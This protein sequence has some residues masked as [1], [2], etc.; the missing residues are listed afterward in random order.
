MNLRPGA[1]LLYGHIAIWCTDQGSS[2]KT[3]IDHHHVGI[4]P[5]AA[6]GDGLDAGNLQRA[7]G[8]APG[9]LRL[10]NG[11]VAQAQS[12]GHGAGLVDQGGAVADKGGAAAFLQ[13]F[14][15]DP[16]RQDG[17]AAAG[18]GH[19]K[20]VLV[21]SLEAFT[22]GLVGFGLE[23]TQCGELDSHGGSL[24]GF[25]QPVVFALDLGGDLF[26]G[27]D[28]VHVAIAAHGELSHFG[29]EALDFSQGGGQFVVG[30]NQ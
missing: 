20:L 24:F 27:G 23:V 5:E 21:A 19:Q 8:V 15:D 13:G 17:L 1:N 16:H 2:R 29:I 4:R 18:G 28:F 7:G 10:D 9:V 3:F 22:Q 25:A 6:L 14:V 26:V 30:I 12:V 11:V